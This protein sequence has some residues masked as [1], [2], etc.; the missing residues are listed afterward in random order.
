[1]KSLRRRRCLRVRMKAHA[2]EICPKARLEIRTQRRGKGL[3]TT[4]CPLARAVSTLPL[5]CLVPRMD[6]CALAVSHTHDVFRHLVSFTFILIVGLADL[7]LGPG[8]ATVQQVAHSPVARRVLQ[9]QQ[10]AAG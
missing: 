4:R 5:H 7:E 1:M 8:H 3:P 9:R 10:R 2:T 6:A